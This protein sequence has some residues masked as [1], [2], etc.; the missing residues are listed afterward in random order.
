[1]TLAGR[2]RAKRAALALAWFVPLWLQYA[3]NCFR[4]APSGWWDAFQQDSESLVLGRLVVARERGFTAHAGHLGRITTRE[5]GAQWFVPQYAYYLEKRALPADWKWTDYTSQVG[6]QGIALSALDRVLPGPPSFRLAAYRALFAAALAACLCQL[7]LWLAGLAGIP[8]AAGFYLA[9]FGSPWLAAFAP[10]LYWAAFLW[11]L[12]CCIT[13]A[14]LARGG[15][16]RRSLA[17]LVA[18]FLARNL[19]GYEYASSVALMAATP[20]VAVALLRGWGLAKTLREGACVGAACV[21]AFLFSLPVFI[22][23]VGRLDILQNRVASRL[24]AGES[25]AASLATRDELGALAQTA[26]VLR[27]YFATS[28]DTPFSHFGVLVPLVAAVAL[29]ALLPARLS[30]WLDQ[31]RQ[32]AQALA[33]T[34]IAAVLAPLS[35]F[36]LATPHSFAHPHMNFVLWHMPFLLF[37]GAALAHLV[38]CYVGR[39]P[40][41]ATRWP[42]ELVTAACGVAIAGLALWIAGP[43]GE[44]GAEGVLAARVL[45]AELLL[46]RSHPPLQVRAAEGQLYLVAPCAAPEL[47]LPFELRIEGPDGDAVVSEVVEFETA[48]LPLRLRAGGRERCVAAHPIGGAM[49]RIEIGQIEPASGYRPWSQEERVVESARAPL[50]AIDDDRWR[51]GVNRSRAGFVIARTSQTSLLAASGAQ[52][53]LAGVTRRVTG[54][55]R[56]KHYINVWLEGDALPEAVA[57]RAT[58]VEFSN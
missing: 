18:A 16:D 2:A 29:V 32:T 54:V 13:A 36:L 1:M 10:N 17:A 19:A 21:A 56:S 23:L 11:F 30:S 40:Q 37:A 8:A 22:A 28:P 44:R 48:R 35:W 25:G 24:G 7:A 50:A 57:A 38:W 46:E 15:F 6:L 3:T 47:E 52:A 33:L 43:R 55:E 41:L 39:R 9:A 49:A 45:D 14:A 27:M 51:N 53:T 5:D 12:P 26:D 58:E 20:V 34:S 31:G 42:E 4:V